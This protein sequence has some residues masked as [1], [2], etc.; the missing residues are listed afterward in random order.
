MEINLT[1]DHGLHR[2]VLGQVFLA[3]GPMAIDCTGSLLEDLAT[4]H[5]T[6]GIRCQGDIEGCLGA[7]VRAVGVSFC[8]SGCS[9][10]S[11]T[12]PVQPAAFLAKL[13]L[14]LDTDNFD[15]SFPRA[16]LLPVLAD[17]VRGAPVRWLTSALFN[18]S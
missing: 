14:G 18:S 10:S 17:S 15:A 8:F 9:S 1:S 2:Q 16:W 7:A 5:E 11:L 13:P 3:L 4:L 6:D 12:V